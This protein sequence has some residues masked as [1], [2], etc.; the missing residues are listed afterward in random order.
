MRTEMILPAHASWIAIAVGLDLGRRGREANCAGEAV[1]GSPT[2]LGDC[3]G[4]SGRVAAGALAFIEP[5]HV[6]AAAQP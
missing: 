2:L 3:P 4:V 6:A 5:W 1:E